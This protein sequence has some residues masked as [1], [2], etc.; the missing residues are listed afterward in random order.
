MTLQGWILIIAFQ[1]EPIQGVLCFML[2]LYWIAY[3]FMN[4][5][6]TWKPAVLIVLGIVLSVGGFVILG[7]VMGPGDAG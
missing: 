6:E 3:V 2:H 5:E 4:L 1:D 7:V